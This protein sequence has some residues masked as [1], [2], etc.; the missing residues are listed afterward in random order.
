MMPRLLSGLD[1]RSPP[2]NPQLNHFYKTSQTIFQ[3]YTYR[4]V[5]TSGI[6]GP[7]YITHIFKL[8]RSPKMS[9]EQIFLTKILK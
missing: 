4:Q 9:K 5:N 2:P 6:N 7:V 1:L 8:S 3:P